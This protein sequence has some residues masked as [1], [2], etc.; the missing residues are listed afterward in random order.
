MHFSLVGQ[1]EL[2]PYFSLFK[3]Y[4]RSVF[5]DPHVRLT[6]DAPLISWKIGMNYSTRV[7][8]NWN[9]ILDAGIMRP[10]G[11]ETY[12]NVNR[13]QSML[14]AGIGVKYYLTSNWEICGLISGHYAF[15]SYKNDIISKQDKYNLKSYSLLVESNYRILK[16]IKLGIF[17]Q[18]FQSEYHHYIS[19]MYWKLYG[20]N[21]KYVLNGKK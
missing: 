2:T 15:S 10:G 17:F 18:P 12:D 1:S 14:Y 5:I 3:S 13:Y 21:I 11:H 19:K 16:K 4:S 20:A 8:N 7:F 9:L 6:A